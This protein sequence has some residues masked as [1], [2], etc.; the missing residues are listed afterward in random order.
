M[1]GGEL[2]ITG[3]DMTREKFFPV[4]WCQMSGHPLQV[5]GD[6]GKKLLTMHNIILMGKN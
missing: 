2:S 3:V 4:G 5:P 1:D 6:S